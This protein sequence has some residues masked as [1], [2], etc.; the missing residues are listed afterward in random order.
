MDFTHADRDSTT[1]QKLKEHY[2][3]RLKVLREQ[4]D[5][6]MSEDKR[7]QLVG[8]IHEVKSLLELEKPKIDMRG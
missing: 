3:A 5:S 1:W 2:E 8:R 6:T 4:N 7:N